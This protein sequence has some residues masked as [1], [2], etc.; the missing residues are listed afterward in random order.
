MKIFSRL[1]LE[2]ISSRLHRRRHFK[3]RI[4]S[5][6]LFDIATGLTRLVQDR[7][8]RCSLPQTA[9]FPYRWKCT[10]VIERRENHGFVF[11]THTFYVFNVPAYSYELI[12]VYVYSWR[13][14]SL[15]SRK[16]KKTVNVYLPAEGR[17]C[18]VFFF[19]SRWRGCGDILYNDFSARIHND[20]PDVR[21]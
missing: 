12:S 7:W 15:Q 13:I 11:G 10:D 3:N 6:R 21:T 14:T 19:D 20:I 2:T 4:T 5:R 16:D 1:V 17:V 9:N 18:L 8:G